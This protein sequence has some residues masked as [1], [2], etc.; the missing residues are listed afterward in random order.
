MFFEHTGIKLKIKNRKI[1]WKS[2]NIWKWTNAF[3]NS[4]WDKEDIKEDFRKYFELTGNENTAYQNVWDATEA[5]HK[6]KLN[7]YII[8]KRKNLYQW[9]Y[10]KKYIKKLQKL[11]P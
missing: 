10:L 11:L 8:K 2:P 6:G 3:L 7:A 1:S 9:F 4:P 5:V